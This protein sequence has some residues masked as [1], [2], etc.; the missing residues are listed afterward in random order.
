MT[1]ESA[2]MES[3][4][5]T[6]ASLG[7][8]A[9]VLTGLSQLEASGGN[10]ESIENLKLLEDAARAL[11]GRVARLG[12]EETA[13]FK[14]VSQLVTV[15]SRQTQTVSGFP[16]TRPRDCGHITDAL[17]N[18]LNSIEYLFKSGD[19]AIGPEFEAVVEAFARTDARAYP[20]EYQRLQLIHARARMLQ[21][22]AAGARALTGFFADRPYLIEAGFHPMLDLLCLDMQARATLGDADDSARRSPFLAAVL[23]AREPRLTLYVGRRMATFIA[24]P[25]PDASAEG[26][27]ARTARFWARRVTRSRRKRGKPLTELRASIDGYV[28][29]LALGATLG[30]LALQVRRGGAGATA[31]ALVTRAMGGIGDLL[32]MTPAFRA[33]SRRLGRPIDVA[34]PRRFFAVFDNNPHVN[35]IDIEGPPL[36]PQ[37]YG[38]WRNFTVCPAG[39]YEDRHKPRVR[40]GRVEIFARALGVRKAELS[41]AGWAVELNVSDELKTFCKQ[42]LR[43]AGFGARPVIGVQ[44]YSRDSYKDHSAIIEIIRDL[45]RD[46][47]VVLFHHRLDGLPTGPGIANTA[48]LSLDKSLAL[49]SVLNAMVSV[50]S[51]F[52]HAASAFD[53]PVVAL[54]GPTDGKTFT[55]HHRRIRVLTKSEKYP[56]VPCWRNEDLPCHVTGVGGH[57]PCVAAIAGEEVRAAIADFLKPDAKSLGSQR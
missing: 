52:L 11:A 12:G 39:A 56:C 17:E 44:P 19:P 29:S 47:D 45:A 2:I 41:A 23:A 26:R 36:A 38:L 6:P 42:F 49:V 3:A 20:G 16:R 25:N 40:R 54:F 10:L 21:G 5:A 13:A 55:A 46:Y 15:L 28:S 50:D 9:D 57:S 18:S 30:L 37:A 8:I 35:L 24:M 14:S 7:E 1:N 34:V 27:L 53:T 31:D 51:A 22:D 43:D 33:L 4:T 32:M 48:G